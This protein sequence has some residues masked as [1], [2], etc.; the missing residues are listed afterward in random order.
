[1]TT[2]TTG[3]E[4]AFRRSGTSGDTQSVSSCSGIKSRTR[5]RARSGGWTSNKGY[6]KATLENQ[7]YNMT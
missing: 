1:M 4:D 5:G 2:M 3:R 6:L 7:S